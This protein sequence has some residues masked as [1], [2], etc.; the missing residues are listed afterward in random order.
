M[1]TLYK[2]TADNGATGW[3][4]NPAEAVANAEQ[5]LPAQILTTDC[6]VETITTTPPPHSLEVFICP[7][8]KR[9]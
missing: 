5:L 4:Y 2:A 3:G 8:S 9:R 1:P 7:A 6:L